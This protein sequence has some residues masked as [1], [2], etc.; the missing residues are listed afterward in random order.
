MLL[1][2][3]VDRPVHE[4]V[5]VEGVGDLHVVVVEVDLRPRRCALPI[6]VDP[7]VRVV[8]GFHPGLLEQIVVDLRTV[9]LINV[10]F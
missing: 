3:Q 8:L 6:D 4:Q 5:V 10:V 1:A 7:T 2:V 9:R